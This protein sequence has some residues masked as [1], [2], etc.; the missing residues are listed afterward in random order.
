MIKKERTY[1][2]RCI[3]LFS[4][5]YYPDGS[6]DKYLN[7]KII[8]YISFQKFESLI[9]SSK[10]YFS[11]SHKVSD[12]R[13]GL[14]SEKDRERLQSYC[15]NIKGWKKISKDKLFNNPKLIKDVSFL[16]CWSHGDLDKTECWNRYIKN[17]EFGIAIITTK[18]KLRDSLKENDDKKHYLFFHG[19]VEYGN[20]T[21]YNDPY[22]LFFRKDLWFDWEN[23]YRVLFQGIK[24]PLSGKSSIKTGLPIDGIQFD[25]NLHKLIEKII[26]KPGS[27]IQQYMQ[28]C[29]LLNSI[30]FTEC[31]IAYSNI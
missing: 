9:T 29:E 2:R 30:N 5:P 21:R 31:L 25:I 6:Y 28:T 19:D 11:N 1:D 18:R 14:P 7:E 17:N 10:L 24:Y 3:G 27:T 8:R 23:E 26:L 12:K 16:S 13:E 20:Y 15:E 22:S 4:K